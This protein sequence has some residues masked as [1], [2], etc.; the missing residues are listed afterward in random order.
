MINIHLI[1]N[2]INGNSQRVAAGIG[3]IADGQHAPTGSGAVHQNYVVLFNQ[4]YRIIINRAF[5]NVKNKIFVGRIGMVYRYPLHRAERHVVAEMIGVYIGHI[6]FLTGT[7]HHD[8]AF[9]GIDHA[10]A[11]HPD[12][13]NSLLNTFYHPVQTGTVNLC[14][15]SVAA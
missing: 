15:L 8:H 13:R 5:L 1:I 14:H 7:I 9:V 2:H 11:V 12:L 3:L 4:K 10:V 6:L